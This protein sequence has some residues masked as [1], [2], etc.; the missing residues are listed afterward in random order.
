L[1]YKRFYAQRL[2]NRINPNA[3]IKARIEVQIGPCGVIVV[4]DSDFFNPTQ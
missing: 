4:I 3:A 1:K 2:L